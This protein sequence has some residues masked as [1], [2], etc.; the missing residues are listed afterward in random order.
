MDF[1]TVQTPL[2]AISSKYISMLMFLPLRFQV[3]PDIP[4]REEADDHLLDVLPV[5]VRKAAADLYGLDSAEERVPVREVGEGLVVLLLYD[6]PSVRDRLRF[7]LFLLHETTLRFKHHK[8]QGTLQGKQS[9]P[10]FDPAGLC[11]CHCSISP[12]PKAAMLL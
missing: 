3:N 2:Q 10:P 8:N 4:V 1:I 11:I 7:F 9:A 5:A 12:L 6:G